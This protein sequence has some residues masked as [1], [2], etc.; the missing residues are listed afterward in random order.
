MYLFQFIGL[1]FYF[2]K[3]LKLKVKYYITLKIYLLLKI[4]TIN[5]Q[6]IK[7]NQIIDQMLWLCMHRFEANLM[8]VAFALVKIHKLSK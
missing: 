2:L 5:K 3:F 1:Y 6:I 7:K 8:P 4:K